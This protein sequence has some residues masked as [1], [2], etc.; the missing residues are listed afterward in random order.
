MVS[1]LSGL[2]ALVILECGPGPPDNVGVHGARHLGRGTSNV[3]DR[4]RQLTAGGGRK[5]Y[6]EMCAMIADETNFAL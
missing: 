3:H 2:D 4:A 6:G 5:C 1:L